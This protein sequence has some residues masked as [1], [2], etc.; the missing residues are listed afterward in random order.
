[1]PDYP[2]IPLGDSE[3]IIIVN[4]FVNSVNPKENTYTKRLY[5]G[6]IVEFDSATDTIISGK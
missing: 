2:G 5:D 3:D 6:T 4:S 1:M